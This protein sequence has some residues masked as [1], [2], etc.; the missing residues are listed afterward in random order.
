[1][2]SGLAPHASKVKYLLNENSTTILTIV[3]VIGTAG[4][5]VLTARATFKAAELIAEEKVVL[6]DHTDGNGYHPVELSKTEKTK[7][8][9][10]LYLL[11][12]STGVLTVTSI[13]VANQ[14]SSKKIAALAV[15]G[16][17]SERALQEYKDKVVEK[18]G[19]KKD[20]DIQDE[21][22]QDRV[23]ANPVSSGEVLVVGTGDVLCYD[24]LTGRYFQSTMEEIKRAENA[25][26]YELIH[27][28]SCSLS[29]FY[30][31]IGLPPTGYTDSV[32]WNLNN[33]MEVKFSTVMSTDNRP[34]LAIDFSRAPIPNFE[35]HWD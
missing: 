4:T 16:G 23:N 24:M 35:K 19:V 2:L 28:M 21:I 5:A 25:V 33:K 14:I 31:E 12:V 3:G 15:A 18:L 29:H 30:D 22:A 26:N 27:F 10:R 32:G 9:W 11:P 1:M 20:Q 17:I 8:V 7:L 34:C 13:I 6:D